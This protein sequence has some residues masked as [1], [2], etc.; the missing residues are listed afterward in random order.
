MQKTTPTRFQDVDPDVWMRDLLAAVDRFLSSEYAAAAYKRDP[1]AYESVVRAKDVLADRLAELVEE[2][3]PATSAA[4]QAAPD[5]AAARKLFG[6]Y[7][8][9]RLS[10]A[11][12]VDAIV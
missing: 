1:A 10:T 2:I 3:V 6:D 8:R 9:I 5:R 4:G 7:L 11:Y 12:T